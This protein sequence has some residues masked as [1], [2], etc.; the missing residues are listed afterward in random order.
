MTP[1]MV[2]GVL[3]WRLPLGD[4]AVAFI[5]LQDCGFYVKWL[6]D[7]PKRAARTS[8]MIAIDHI[9]EKRLAEAFTRVTGMPAFHDDISLE[10]YWR[11]PRL[12]VHAK[13]PTASESHL[14][15]LAAMTFQ[16][17]FSGFWDMWKASGGMEG[18]VK[19]YYILLDHVLSG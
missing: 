13:G 2:D 15:D 18:A 1:D 17:N 12:A 4:S 11:Q 16:E 19:R 7:N 9:S 5:D 8:L 10:D 6:F 14:N 3:T